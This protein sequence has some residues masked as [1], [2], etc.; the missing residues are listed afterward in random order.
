MLT[1]QHLIGANGEFIKTFSP[2]L[3]KLQQIVLEL[4]GIPESSYR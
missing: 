1:R 4:L 2:E 3:S